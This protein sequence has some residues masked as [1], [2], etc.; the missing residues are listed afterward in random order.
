ME[1][2]NKGTFQSGL[3][4]LMM[5]YSVILGGLAFLYAIAE[6]LVFVFTGEYLGQGPD[7]GNDL[8]T[9]F[10]DGIMMWGVPIAIATAPGAISE[11]VRGTK[12]MLPALLIAIIGTIIAG[13]LIAVAGG[14]GCTIL[15]IPLAFVSLIVMAVKSLFAI[16]WIFGVIGAVIGFSSIAG[17]LGMGGA[18]AVEGFIA[19]IF[20]VK[21]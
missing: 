3:A 14:I 11:L 8:I 17:F 18:S 7:F 5:Y 6:V 20:R 12:D 15:L 21:K 1:E 9:P 16:H 13:L 4:D 2:T 10:K 19:I